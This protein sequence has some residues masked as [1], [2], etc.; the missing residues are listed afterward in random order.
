MATA[1]RSLSLPFNG[2][3]ARHFRERQGLT[4]TQLAKR[5]EEAG[6][7]INHSTLSR[8]EADHF[9]PT[10]TR[11]RVLATALGVEPEDLCGPLPDVPDDQDAAPSGTR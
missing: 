9:G 6:L 2:L 1:T 7:R 11:F 4:L 5:C 8:Y 10:V 3:R